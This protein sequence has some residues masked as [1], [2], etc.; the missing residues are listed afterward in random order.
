[1]LKALRQ[2]KDF[3]NLPVV[4]TSSLVNPNELA[5]IEHLGVVRYFEKPRDLEGFFQMALGLK[6]IL[7][8][9]PESAITV[10]AS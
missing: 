1:V 2:S 5:E 9:H 4:I 6:Q 7:L 8:E 10:G 3:A